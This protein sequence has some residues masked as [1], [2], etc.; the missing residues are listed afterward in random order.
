MDYHIYCLMAT[1][2]TLQLLT[3][4]FTYVP[5]YLCKVPVLTPYFHRTCIFATLFCKKHKISRTYV[6]SQPSCSMWADGKMDL[7]IIHCSFAK[8][9]N[10]LVHAADI[11]PTEFKHL[12]CIQN[13]ECACSDQHI[14]SPLLSHHHSPNYKVNREC[15]GVCVFVVSHPDT[16]CS[17]NKVG[18]LKF[19]KP[20]EI[21]LTLSFSIACI[22]VLIIV[23]A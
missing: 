15:R 14:A 13:I 19:Y 8:R 1:V 18:L 11:L 23:R 7:I 17:C 6:T 21:K 16:Q 9:F 3:Q 22:S 20:T 12:D 2:T 5:R 10:S 4:E